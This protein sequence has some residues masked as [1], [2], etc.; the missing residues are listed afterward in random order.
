MPVQPAPSECRLKYKEEKLTTLVTG[1]SDIVV[2]L[3]AFTAQLPILAQESDA[4]EEKSKQ[5]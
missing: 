4:L 1:T 2:D 5:A 3:L